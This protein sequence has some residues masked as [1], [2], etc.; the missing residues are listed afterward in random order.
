[1]STEQRLD[2]IEA[3]LDKQMIMFA[4]LATV[5][6]FTTK[7]VLPKE[8][9]PLTTGIVGPDEAARILNLPIT[10]GKTHTRRLKYFREHGFLTKFTGTSPYYYNVQELKSLAQRIADGQVM[11]PPV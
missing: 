3:L 11:I 7:V 10:K 5:L 6:E 1:M 9:A 8:T 4:N 2:R